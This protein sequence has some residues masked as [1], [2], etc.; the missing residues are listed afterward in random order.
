MKWLE[1]EFERSNMAV[2]TFNVNGLK[3]INIYGE[4]SAV[5]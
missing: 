1:N 4:I 3:A 5:W 2:Q